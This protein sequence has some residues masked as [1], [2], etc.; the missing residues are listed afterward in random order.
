MAFEFSR[1]KQ[2]IRYNKPGAY[3]MYEFVY[4]IK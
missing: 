3:I 1:Y 2:A 4:A